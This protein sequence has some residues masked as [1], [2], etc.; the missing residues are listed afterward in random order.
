ML[1]RSTNPEVAVSFTG[2]GFSRYFTR[3]SYQNTA[4]SK[5]VTNLGTKYAGLYNPNGRAYPDIAAQGQSF[6]V[7]IGGFVN[8]V[9]G[10]SASS[11][12][13]AGVLS[14]VNDYRLSH[15]KP[16]LG[17]I[18]PLIYSTGATAFNDITSGSNPGCGTN[19]FSAATGWDPVTGLG[20]PD[21]LKLQA[22]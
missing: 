3:P 7:V 8:S 10:T 18:N 14:L 16:S 12:A 19:G 15:G 20:T 22:L 21:F 5:Y 17:F 1:F 6:Q 2:G 13:A 11:P 9:S 4:V